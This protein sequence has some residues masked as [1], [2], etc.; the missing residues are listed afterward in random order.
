MIYEDLQDTPPEIDGNWKTSPVLIFAKEPKGGPYLFR[1]VYIRDAQ[2]SR[3][4]HHVVTRVGIRVKLIGQPAENI[5][6]QDD[7]RNK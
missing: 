5:E 6:I 4:K 2:K 1:G 3:Y 7:F